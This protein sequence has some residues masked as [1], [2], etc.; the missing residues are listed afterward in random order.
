MII[1][2]MDLLYTNNFDGFCIV[3]SDSDFTRLATRLRE[4]G[5]EVMGFG[6]KIT[7]EPFRVACNKF[8]FTEVL[9]NSSDE[10]KITDDK[11]QKPISVESATTIDS[12]NTSNLKSL[13]KESIESLQGNDGFANLADVGGFIQRIKPDF[14]PRNYGGTNKK[15]GDLVKKQVYIEHRMEN[16]GLFIR[17]NGIEK[18]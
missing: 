3:S 11:I 5:L 7:P 14:D 6:R 13:L 17:F 9:L 1:D 8:T 2:A 10:E 16:G 15:L 12:N 18:V 4:S